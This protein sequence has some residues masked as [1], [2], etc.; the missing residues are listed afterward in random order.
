MKYQKGFTLI[1]VLVVVAVIGILAS[2]LLVGLGQVRT[3]GQDARRIADLA[4]MRNVL[5]VYAAKCGHYPGGGSGGNC[6][7]VAAP[8]TWAGLQ[9]VL[10]DSGIIGASD[11]IPNDPVTGANYAYC[12]LGSDTQPQSYVL[13]AKL[14]STDHPALA[15]DFDG[16]ALDCQGTYTIDCGLDDTTGFYCVKL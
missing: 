4:T 16:S 5:E 14:T 7:S 11:S 9:T 1:E 15:N 2:I 3:R 13:Q 12:S 8:T 6:S 10:R